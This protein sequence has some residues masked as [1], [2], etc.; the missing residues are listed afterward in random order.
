MSPGGH[1]VRRG[2]RAVRS[3]VEDGRA[4]VPASPRAQR[5][6]EHRLQ[7]LVVVRVVEESLRR[8]A[9]LP[10]ADTPGIVEAVDRSTDDGP[11]RA[12]QHEAE[13]VGEVGLARPVHP[14]DGDPRHARDRWARHRARHGLEHA[15][16]I[17]HGGG[18]AMPEASNIARGFLTSICSI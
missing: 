6:E 14:V 10:I 15:L 9:A 16:P 13:L 3:V 1:A 12:P 8:V 4:V 11:P 2:D 7:L 17:P 5:I 18:Y